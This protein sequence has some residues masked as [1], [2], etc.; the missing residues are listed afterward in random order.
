MEYSKDITEMIDNLES[1]RVQQEKQLR[2][3]GIWMS[4]AGAIGI[5]T[6]IVAC[7]DIQTT[8]HLL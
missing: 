6:L 3:S 4:G 1:Y 5:L 7:M 8:L 2:T